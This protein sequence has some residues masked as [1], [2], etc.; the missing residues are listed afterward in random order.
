LGFLTEAET[1]ALQKYDHDHHVEGGQ[2]F[3][4]QHWALEIIRD[5]V[6]EWRE[7][8]DC[9]SA[10]FD[11]VFQVRDCQSDVKNKMSNPMPFQYFQVMSFML[12]FNLALWGYS[13]AFQ[14]TFFALVAYF[15]I[16]L[17]YVGLRELCASLSN[18]FGS[19]DVDFPVNM[20][21]T[22]LSWDVAALVESDF[23]PLDQVQAERQ[24]KRDRLQHVEFRSGADE[25]DERR[26]PFGFIIQMLVLYGTLYFFIVEGF[27]SH[28]MARDW[29]W[30]DADL[31]ELPSGIPL[32]HQGDSST[33]SSTTITTTSTTAVTT[34]AP[35]T[36]GT[37]TSGEKRGGDGQ[38]GSVF[39][40]AA[41]AETTT[42]LAPETT[43]PTTTSV[44]TTS[45]TTVTKRRCTRSGERMDPAGVECSNCCIGLRPFMVHGVNLRTLDSDVMSSPSPA[46]N[47]FVCYTNER[48]CRDRVQGWCGQWVDPCRNFVR[49]TS[50]CTDRARDVWDTGV[51]LPCCEGMQWMLVNSG[52]NW[53]YRCFWRVDDCM[54][55]ADSCRDPTKE[56][57]R[58][59][60]C[61]EKPRKDSPSVWSSYPQ[62][63]SSFQ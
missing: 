50:V 35:M 58:P 12:F 24:M 29:M 27:S 8:D 14:D 21:L 10:F 38:G 7:R 52:G 25:E 15:F 61:C 23:K 18:P 22:N 20:W 44:A 13:L 5:A 9:M 17:I 62:L 41:V 63:P 4:V 39:P 34:A 49:E 56:E 48:E 1:Q 43:M 31:P 2:A 28:S 37:T 42:A 53:R 57:I 6:P 19:E 54:S 40:T 36:P 55:S 26:V 47:E 33:S 16:Q 3:T 60:S 51:C 46:V 59:C 11:K 45:T 30:P 32:L